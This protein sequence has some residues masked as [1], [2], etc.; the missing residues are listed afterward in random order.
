MKRLLDLV[1]S[2]V[3][4]LIFAPVLIVIA[5]LIKRGSKGPVFFVQKR[6]GKDGAVF[7]M[8]KFRTMVDNA[9]S[10]GTG[11]F[12]YEDDPRITP[13]GATLRRFSLDEL[14]QLLNVF[15]GSMSL[16]GPRPPVTYE[17]GDYKDFT[18][19]MKVRFQVKQGIT[20]LAQ[21][22]GRN[23]LEWDDKIVFDNEYVR[24]YK[25]WGVLYDITILFRTVWVVLAG[26]GVI[27]AEKPDHEHPEGKEKS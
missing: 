24:I 20:G 15:L 25:K 19:T 17:L 5:V 27:E 26:R 21:V 14:P 7:E 8:F 1:G 6:L 2:S 23:E 9:E 22:S 12:S 3:A 10:M 18:D 4:L 13:I 16:V 11:L